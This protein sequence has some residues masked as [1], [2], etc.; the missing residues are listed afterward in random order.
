MFIRQRLQQYG[1]HHA[2]N[3]RIR[4]DSQAQRQNCRDREPWALAHH[5]QR[6]SR[7]LAEHRQVLR[8]RRPENSHNRFPP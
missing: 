1:I 8:W 4:A 5:S 3:R 6:K 2:E 7:I